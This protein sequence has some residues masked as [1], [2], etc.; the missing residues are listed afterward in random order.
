[1]SREAREIF[2]VFTSFILGLRVLAGS[3]PKLESTV[4]TL[5]SSQ[6]SHV[7]KRT[8]LLGRAVQGGSGTLYGLKS[9]LKVGVPEPPVQR[10]VRQPNGHEARALPWKHEDRAMIGLLG[11]FR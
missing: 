4:R 5:K 1:M 2:F 3:P 9:N 7:A 11:T 10:G 8:V 6:F